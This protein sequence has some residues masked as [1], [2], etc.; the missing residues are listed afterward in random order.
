MLLFLSFI[1]ILV[2]SLGF[3]PSIQSSSAYIH[4]IAPTF[5]IAIQHVALAEQKEKLRKKLPPMNTTR[6][7]KFE[8]EFRELLEGM[9]H[10]P[11]EIE[12]VA[13]PRLRAIYDGVAASY[14]EP[15][16]YRAFEVL[17]EDYMPLRVAGRI[18][19][20]KLNRII[21]ES[22]QDREEQVQTVLET[23]N[24]PVDRIQASWKYFGQLAGGRTIPIQKV[25]SCIAEGVVELLG[26]DSVD[27]MIERLDP[28]KKG[29]L[30]FSDLICGLH[31]CAVEHSIPFEEL[32]Q[33]EPSEC[34]PESLTN[35]HKRKEKYNRKYD[36]M[37]ETFAGWKD[38]IPLGE[39]RRLDV[40]RG[41]FVGSENPKVVQ[42]LRII[43]VDNSALRMSGD[44]IF[45]LVSTLM[46]GAPKR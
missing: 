13:N 5:S 40:L 2:P 29:E 28:E 34:M 32:L 23:T 46:S 14:H 38:F 16:V 12:S 25:K 19:Y 4:P 9:L 8:I 3:V 1:V 27:R 43:Y 35:D 26:F 44:W 31:R 10:T 24:L 42:A 41:C 39:G 15:E 30:R 37:I 18:I 45:K 17:Y 11:Q 6:M 22:Q 21:E 7:S 20:R 36:D 33:F